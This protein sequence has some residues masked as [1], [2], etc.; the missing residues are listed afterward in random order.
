MDVRRLDTRSVVPNWSPQRIPKG[1]RYLKWRNLVDVTSYANLAAPRSDPAGTVSL[2]VGRNA[3]TV[4]VLFLPPEMFDPIITVR[5][6][7]PK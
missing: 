7:D 3:N 2:L 6:S 1:K 5:Q 4:H